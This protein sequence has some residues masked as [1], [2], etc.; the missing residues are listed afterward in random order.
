MRQPHRLPGRWRN[1]CLALL[2]LA[3]SCPALAWNAA[4]HRLSAAIAWREMTPA[5]REAVGTLLAAHPDQP[6]WL[7]HSKESDAD[8]AA[9]LAASTWAD[10]IKRDR[11]FYDEG[12]PPTAAQQG[13]PEMARHRHWH[14][15]DHR[16]DDGRRSGD[17]ELDRRLP[18]LMRTLGDR[19]ASVAARSY[20]LPWLIHLVADA[21]QPL[22]LA[23]RHDAAGTSDRGGNGLRVE[24]PHHPR[25]REMS[26]H[27]YWDD[28]PGPPWLRGERLEATAT[29]LVHSVP[30]S[31]ARRPN[32]EDAA[33]VAGWIADSRQLARTVAYADVDGETPVIGER[34]HER[35]RRTAERQIVLAGRRLA[36]LLEHLIGD[37]VSRGTADRTG[38]R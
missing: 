3:A 14:H 8:Y 12:A 38:N 11:R 5:T 6:R 31:G 23:S 10:D 13:F 32:E 33:D 20:A 2:L 29:A 28:L 30:D 7:A 34:Y 19:Q 15:A 36:R 24:T 17:G 16:L 21:H 37:D 1:G 18:Q 22:H 25:L 27:A 9:F 26:L 35:A 4:G